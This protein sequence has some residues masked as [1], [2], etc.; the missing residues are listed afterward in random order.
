MLQ[1]PAKQN[2][3]EEL[4]AYCGTFINIVSTSFKGDPVK[5][6]GELVE[7]YFCNFTSLSIN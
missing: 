4:V 7:F 1:V 3:A 2:F 6:A 5:E